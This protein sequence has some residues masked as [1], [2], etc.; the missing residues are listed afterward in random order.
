VPQAEDVELIQMHFKQVGIA[1]EEPIKN[2]SRALK[3]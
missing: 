3:V 2:L 1:I